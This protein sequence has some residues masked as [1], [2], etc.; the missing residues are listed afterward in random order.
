MDYFELVEEQQRGVELHDDALE[1]ELLASCREA[2]AG[3]SSFAATPQLPDHPFPKPW[4]SDVKHTDVARTGESVTSPG[5]VGYRMAKAV[6]DP[7]LRFLYNV[8]VEGLRHL[9][10]QGG[11]ILA[12][13]HRSFMDS[14]FLALTSP[15]PIVFVAKA[16]YFDNPMTRWLF[17]GT[18]QIPVRRGSPKGAR[19][20]LAAGAEVLDRGGVIG[21]YPEGTRSRDGNLGRGNRGPVHLA[22]VT[23]AP[24]VPVGLIGTETVQRPDERVPRPFRTVT[25]RFG[26]ARDIAHR[27][28]GSTATALRRATDDV[29]HEI[30]HLCGQHYD[31]G[32]AASA[33]G[34][35]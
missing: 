35:P 15:R 22:K 6:L 1:I 20:A 33:S 17:R 29:M 10:E 13:N 18:G 27:V 3:F 5:A 30:A 26:E 2:C 32:R 12:A 24:I 25:V 28:H 8:H 34:L 11:V 23:G 7:P 9:P 16:E 14:I 4:R 21:I 19:E 31:A